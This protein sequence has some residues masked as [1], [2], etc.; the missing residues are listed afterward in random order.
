MKALVLDGYTDEPACLGVPPF[1]SPYARLAYGALSAAGADVGYATID[2]WRRSG[3]KLDGW[4]LLTVIRNVAV[5]GKYLRGMPA[6]D[7]ELLAI[8]Q[9]FHGV[10][11]LSLGLE[12]SLAPASLKSAFDFI[13][14]QDLDASLFDLLTKKQFVDRRRTNAEWNSWLARG[15]DVCTQHPDHSGPLT[16]E[17]QM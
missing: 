12:P 16:A 17:V 8:G 4:N 5:P 11:V 14:S 13:S 9:R 2:Q 15:V 1:L 6:S 10:K 7:K 3:V